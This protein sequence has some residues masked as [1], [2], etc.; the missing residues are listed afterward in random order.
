MKRYLKLAGFVFIGWI[1]TL[2]LW[3][4]A[5]L[6]PVAS[7]HD[8]QMGKSSRFLCSVDFH[9]FVASRRWNHRLLMQPDIKTKRG[10]VWI[11]PGLHFVL[12]EAAIFI[13][14]AD[15]MM[16]GMP[17][18]ML[19][20]AVAA[21]FRFVGWRWCGPLHQVRN[22][23][24]PHIEQWATTPDSPA[25]VWNVPGNGRNYELEVENHEPTGLDGNRFF[26]EDGRLSTTNNEE[27]GP[28]M[29]RNLARAV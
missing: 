20:A 25:G 19:L 26:A 15:K 22:A 16:P 5:S 28:R 29:P 18:M 12:L 17:E 4:L 2:A 21:V 10:F 13:L 8:L 23:K 14:C 3:L 6:A 1:S 7:T 24:T 11:T 27:T 9:A